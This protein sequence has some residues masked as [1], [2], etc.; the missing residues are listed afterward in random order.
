M[1]IDRKL[2]LAPGDM[3]QLEH[4]VRDQKWFQVAG[5]EDVSNDWGHGGRELPSARLQARTRR[6]ALM[7]RARSRSPALE[8]ERKLRKKLTAV[9]VA[10]RI[11]VTTTT[12][13]YARGAATGRNTAAD[14]IERVLRG[15]Q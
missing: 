2:Q 14:W 12:T 8:R 10:L 6:G 11:D 3:V 15:D 1:N 7:T 4:G 13:D 5:R 9:V